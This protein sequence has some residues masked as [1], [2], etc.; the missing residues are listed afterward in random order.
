MRWSCETCWY[1]L[2]RVEAARL[3]DDA[4]LEPPSVV[5]TI[6]TDSDTC[7]S[8]LDAGLWRVTRELR[9]RWRFFLE[10]KRL[11]GGVVLPHCHVLV[12]TLWPTALGTEL[13]RAAADAGLRAKAETAQSVAAAIHYACGAGEGKHHQRPP[14]AWSGRRV[15]GSQNY[16]ARRDVTLVAELTDGLRKAGLMSSTLAK[17]AVSEIAQKERN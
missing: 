7:W 14:A 1:S 2:A 3:L 15:R 12:K 4:V 10:W 17:P 13:E 6:T 9:P 8:A 5:A 11:P 16:F